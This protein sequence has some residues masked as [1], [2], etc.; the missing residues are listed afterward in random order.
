MNRNSGGRG[1]GSG[2]TGRGRQSGGN[3]P[4]AGPG[5]QCVCPNCGTKA[6]HIQGEPCFNKACP[7]CGSKMTRE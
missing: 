2:M 4:G 7:K 1:A 3:R 5:G 6:P